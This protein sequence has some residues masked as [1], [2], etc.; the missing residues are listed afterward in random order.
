MVQPVSRAHKAEARPVAATSL[1]LAAIV[2]GFGIIFSNWLPANAEES[3]DLS[4]PTRFEGYPNA[5]QVSVVPRKDALFFYPCDQCHESM[6][7]NPEIRPL[8]AMHV[9]ALEQD[10]KSVV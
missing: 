6:E 5:P 10:R 8:N 9:S 3:A 7:P 4:Q 2:I 1:P